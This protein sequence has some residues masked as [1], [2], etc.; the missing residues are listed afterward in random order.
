LAFCNICKFQVFDNSVSACP[1]CGAPLE[2][3]EKNEEVSEQTSPG[4][5]SRDDRGHDEKDDDLQICDPG[6]Y[7]CSEQ[8]GAD[9]PDDD[10]PIGQTTPPPPAFDRPD[11]DVEK[12]PES[13]QSAG[14]SIKRLSDEQV[15]NIRSNLLNG[16]S[17]YVSAQD[18]SSIIHD[19]SKS[20]EGPTLQRQNSDNSVESVKKDTPEVPP[21]A[22]VPRPENARSQD[23]LPAPKT[24]PMRKVAYFHKNFIQLTGSVHPT[25]GEEM[26]IDDRHY[27]LKQK[28]IKPQYTIGMFSILVV[29]LL[30]VIGKQFISPTL[31]GDG[32]IIGVILDETGRPLING[33][34]I[35]L[36]ESGQKTVSNPIGFFRFDQVPTGVYVVRYT[37]PDGKVGTENISVAKDDITMLSLT[38]D[39]AERPVSSRRS[40]DTRQSTAT[41]HPDTKSGNMPPVPDEKKQEATQSSTTQKAYSEI[42]L[43]ANVEGAKLVVNGETLGAG[44][45]TYKKLGPGDH[46]ATV[47]KSG[48]KS[49]SGKIHLNPNETYT[50]SVTLEKVQDEAQETAYSADDFY[51]SGRTMLSEGNT[52]AAI[53]DFTEAINLKPSLADAYAGRAE[54]Y[55]TVGKNSPAEADY[56]RA[57][58]IYVSQKRDESAMTCFNKALGIN[59]S[60]LVALLNR[61]DLHRRADRKDQAVDDYRAVLKGDKENFRANFEMGKI[62]FS[63]ANHKDADKMLRKAREINAQNPEVYH[64]LMLNYFARDDF[65]KVKKTYGDFKENVS[66]DQQQAFRENPRFDAILRIV[67]EYERP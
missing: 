16:N 24:A 18:A 32:T 51:Q 56:V 4:M 54:A 40:N 21:P 35:A 49:W 67:G 8:A 48:Y 38:S 44:N 33:A 29:L 53:Q 7:L 42:K 47:T 39:G 13:S 5:A 55:Q 31:P 45:M 27:L 61:G 66:D 65:G 57:G 15:N 10:G 46:K 22:T 26:V 28:K 58:E 30:F 43:R 2:N 20:S 6:E 41:T 19:L 64:Y 52:D 36:P 3:P 23:D 62:Y 34:E 14:S 59:K 60:S 37:L 63:T 12:K 11:D 50:L 17:E 9:D 1:N 25:T